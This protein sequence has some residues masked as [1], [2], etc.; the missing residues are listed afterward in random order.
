MPRQTQMEGYV[1]SAAKSP[2]EIEQQR[3]TI[4]RKIEAFYKL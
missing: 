1:L 2:T 4:K 3:K